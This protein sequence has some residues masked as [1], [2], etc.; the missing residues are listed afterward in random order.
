MLDQWSN[1]SLVFF[2]IMRRLLPLPLFIFCLSALAQTHQVD[3]DRV[4]MMPDLPSPYIMRD[5][6]D[7]A[8]KYDDLVYSTLVKTKNSSVNYPGLQPI[9]LESYIGGDDNAAESINIIPS[10]VG[11]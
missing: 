3:I 11:A 5:W 6:K 7:V 1:C 10:I 2:I 9:L 4:N 8:R